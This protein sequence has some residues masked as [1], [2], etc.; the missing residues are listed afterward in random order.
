MTIGF[1]MGINKRDVRFVIHYSMPKS[2]ELYMQ[3]CDRA[4]RDNKFAVCILYYKYEDIKTRE[5]L[6]ALYS[7]QEYCEEPFLCRRMMQL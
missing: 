3:E 7:I 5:N 6:N 1:G 4:G 2:L